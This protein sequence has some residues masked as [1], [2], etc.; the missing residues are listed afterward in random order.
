MA[1][2]S[3]KWVRSVPHEPKTQISG[4][5]AHGTTAAFGIADKVGHIR[6]VAASHDT[7]AAVYRGSAAC[8]TAVKRHAPVAGI[9]PLPDVSGQV[10]KAV[11]I[12]T[13]RP[14]WL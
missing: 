8:R 3:E 12:N 5:H 9:R 10:C 6:A 4:R 7:H 2:A 11:F 14:G 1:H 13:E